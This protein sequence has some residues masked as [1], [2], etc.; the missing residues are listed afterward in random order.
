MKTYIKR[1]RIIE[2]TQ[3]EVQ[4]FHETL[5]KA[6]QGQTVNYAETQLKDGTS[7][8]VDIVTEEEQRAREHQRKMASME[9]RGMGRMTDVREVRDGVWP[10][11]R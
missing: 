10:K 1:L 5:R 9:Q 7:L 6:E 8:G 4:A 3:E 2:M 11:T